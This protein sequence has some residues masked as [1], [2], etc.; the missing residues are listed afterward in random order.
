M[1]DYYFVIFSL[2]ARVQCIACRKFESAI[3]ELAVCLPNVFFSGS[4]S[5]SYL[6]DSHVF[7]TG[8][9]RGRLSLNAWVWEENSTPFTCWATQMKEWLILEYDCVKNTHAAGKRQ[10]APDS[11]MEWS[12]PP[13]LNVCT[14]SMVLLLHGCTCDFVLCWRHEPGPRGLPVF[15]PVGWQQLAWSEQSK[16]AWQKI[17]QCLAFKKCR[18]PLHAEASKVNV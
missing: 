9:R 1:H 3:Q 17:P 16:R 18:R 11:F 13:S 15:L 12:R 8:S 2:S 7:P 4:P 6:S 14:V 5:S 10:I